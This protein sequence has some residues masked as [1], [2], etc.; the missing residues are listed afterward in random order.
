MT[1]NLRSFAMGKPSALTL[2]L[3]LASY[4]SPCAAERPPCD[5]KLQPGA[6]CEV[7]V[8]LLH[9]TQFAIGFR[10]V[11]IRAGKIAQMKPSKLKKY[12][13]ERI[14]PL[15][16]SPHGAPYILDHHHFVAA[17]I[18]SGIRKTVP[19]KIMSNA[20]E[21]SEDEFWK[22]MRERQWVH[23]YDEKGNGPVSVTLLPA[24]VT[25]LKD[26]PLRSLAWAVR[27]EGGYERHDEI[28]YADF[29]WANF[30]RQHI[31]FEDTDAGFSA[32]IQN[33][34]HLAKTPAA[35][36]LPGYK[37]TEIRP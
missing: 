9:P 23:P 34:L 24:S 25:G 6:E 14:V 36:N 20:A 8:N 31:T 3:A 2:L 32:A 21:A 28:A 16:I 19:A 30:F 37:A 5:V 11:H 1:N 17:I 26:D 7:A 22:L 12:L 4:F 29:K 27:E 10:E 33:A 13:E 35:K 18:E 15:A